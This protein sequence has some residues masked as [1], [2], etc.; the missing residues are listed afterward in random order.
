MIFVVEKLEQRQRFSPHMYN[1]PV[2]QS[3][4]TKKPYSHV[5]YLPPALYKIS[6]IGSVVKKKL[7][8]NIGLIT[9]HPFLSSAE[10]SLAR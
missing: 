3:Y 8:Q 7:F 2:C 4:S 9:P 1:S 6:A 5:I 10:I